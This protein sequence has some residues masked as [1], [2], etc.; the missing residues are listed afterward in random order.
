MSHSRILVLDSNHY[1]IDC[2][3]I[4][5]LMQTY[6][7]GVDSVTESDSSYE[8]D[9]NWFKNWAE[10]YGIEVKGK[11]FTIKDESLFYDKMQEQV[12][13]GLGDIRGN[14]RWKA[15]EALR[16]VHGFWVYHKDS[17][18]TL[19]YFMEEIKEGDTFKVKS[20]LDYHY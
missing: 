8:S 20:F 12:L 10:D 1:K 18:L 13:D 16:M 4:F 7:N 6:G 14:G 19:P 11:K 9:L 5:E 15:T 3:D 2:D 17:L